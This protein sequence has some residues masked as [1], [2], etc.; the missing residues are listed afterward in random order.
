MGR[1]MGACLVRAGF[2]VTGFDVSEGAR[3][4]FAKDSGAS[5]AADMAAAVRDADVV[6]T[7][8]PDGKIVRALVESLQRDLQAGTVIIDMSS[9]EPMGTRDLGAKMIAAGFEFIDAP[10]SGG[11]RRAVDGSLSIMAGGDT[12][13]LDRAGPVLSAMGRTIFRTGPLGSGHAMKAL[14][15]YVSG[16]GLIAACEAINAGAAFG[17]DPGLMVDVLNAST[18]RNNSTEVKMK[19]FILSQSW[20]SGFSIGLMAKD[21]R[22]AGD[23]AEKLGVAAP[24]AEHCADLWDEAVAR[25]G[26]AC[27]HTEVQRFLEM[28]GNDDG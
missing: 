18:G 22:T 14:N 15:N 21:I 26:G 6:I 19:Q 10:V 9:S 2:A 1:P 27:D 3:T 4:V 12:A 17:I 20:G 8:V 23:L 25:I 16:A 7:M 13:T 11:V 5:I 24:L 28:Y